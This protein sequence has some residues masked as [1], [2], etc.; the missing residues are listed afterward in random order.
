MKIENNTLT[1]DNFVC[2]VKS[3][4]PEGIYPVDFIS[5]SVF[6]QGEG[7]IVNDEWYITPGKS[8][9]DC[10]GILVAERFKEGRAINSYKVY[11]RL[12]EVLEGYTALNLEVY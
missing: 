7:Y 11:D 3:N 12:M 6:P 10:Q 9:K 1:I 4:V 5:S 2:E 8:Q